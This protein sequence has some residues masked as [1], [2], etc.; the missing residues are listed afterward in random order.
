M[1]AREKI[2][3]EKLGD[4]SKSTLLEIVSTQNSVSSDA[5]QY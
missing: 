3:L 5:W 2:T 1:N 4:V